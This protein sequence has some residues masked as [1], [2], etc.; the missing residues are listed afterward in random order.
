[1]TKPELIYFDAPGRAEPIRM[2]LHFA[3]IEYED[4]RFPGSEWPAIKPTTPL[5]FVPV[6]KIDGKQYCQSLSLT[7]YAAKLADWYPASEFQAL[8]CDMVA[9]TINELAAL[10]PKSK[11][12][13]ELKKLR[14]E[15]Q[16]DTLTKYWKFVEGI[17][18]ENGGIL[19]SGS[20]PT[21]AD[22]LIQQSVL[23]IKLGFWDHIDTNFF[24]DY[25]GLNATCKAVEENEKVKAYM[26]AKKK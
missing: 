3:G 20:T 16:K 14:Q 22:L 9:E 17:I 1:M 10:A 12:Q 18:Q 13:D 11:D 5:G 25:P 2:L 26:A 6:M 21:F 23:M 4:T 7:R 15:F 24:D 19:V 8:K